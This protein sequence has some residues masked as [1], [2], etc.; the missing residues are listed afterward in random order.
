MRCPFAPL[1]FVSCHPLTNWIRA[2]M[3]GEQL[4]QMLA[5]FDVETVS[6]LCSQFIIA[7]NYPSK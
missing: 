2:K 5:E 3:T 6:T 4:T 1:S 7:A